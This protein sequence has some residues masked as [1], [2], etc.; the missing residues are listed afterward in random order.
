MEYVFWN[1]GKSIPSEDGHEINLVD[2]SQKCI[3][4][5]KFKVRSSLVNEKKNSN[6]NFALSLQ[7]DFYF[8]VQYASNSAISFIA[9][10]QFP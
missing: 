2:I 9:F 8:C 3:R 5:E 1:I 7:K 4:L 10:T 6:G